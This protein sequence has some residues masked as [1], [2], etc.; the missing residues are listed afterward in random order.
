ME[1][2]L[3]ETHGRASLHGRATLHG[4]ASLLGR[5]TLLGRASDNASSNKSSCVS[6]FSGR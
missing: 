6:N 2:H 5:A 4:R 1:T 3:V